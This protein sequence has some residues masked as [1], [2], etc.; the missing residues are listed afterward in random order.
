MLE[1]ELNLNILQLFFLVQSVQKETQTF[2]DIFRES[3]LLTAKTIFISVA[4]P[5]N[6]GP[7]NRVSPQIGHRA[8]ILG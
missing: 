4:L 5:F 2:Y 8:L 3:K 7:K 1:M 6:K